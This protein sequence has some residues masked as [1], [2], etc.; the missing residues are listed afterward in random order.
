M[1]AAGN[2]YVTGALLNGA[3]SG[4]P[5]TRVFGSTSL[6]S[7]FGLASGFVAKLLPTQ[8]WLWAVR[9]TH[10]VEDATFRNV[11]VSP[12]GDTYAAG[13][14]NVNPLVGGSGTVTVGSFRAVSKS[15][16]VWAM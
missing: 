9:A 11:T 3:G 10:T 5:A 8:Q 16:Y 6:S 12:A 1:D 15:V 2:Q 14:A 4:A 7:G 13:I